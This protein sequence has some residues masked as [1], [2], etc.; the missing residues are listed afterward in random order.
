MSLQYT[1]NPSVCTVISNPQDLDDSIRA[2]VGYP[3]GAVAMRFR[4][5]IPEYGIAT[6]IMSSF[7]FADPESVE[8]G[9]PLDPNR[10]TLTGNTQIMV[11]SD[12]PTA[13]KSLNFVIDGTQ[14]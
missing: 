6:V 5:A 1:L 12:S 13:R 7:L 11:T 8:I 4:V 9:S 3:T 10:L 2:T 14:T